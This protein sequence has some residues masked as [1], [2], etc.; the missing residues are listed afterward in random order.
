MPSPLTLKAASI[1]ELKKKATETYGPTAKVVRVE[2]VTQ[3]GIAGMFANEHFEGVIEIEPVSAPKAAAHGFADLTGVAALLAQ[4][5]AGENEMNAS[6]LPEVSTHGEDFTKLMESLNAE[7]VDTV[8]GPPTLSWAAGDL[9]L[10]AGTGVYALPVARAMAAEAG[11][12]LYTSGL[13]EADGVP[14]AEGPR[15]VMEARANGVL[16]GK[17]V[18]LAFGLGKPAWAASS[19]VTAGLLKADQVWLIVDA[20]HKPA[21]TESWG[22][23]AIK[24]LKPSALAVVGV[25]E[26]ASPSTVNTLGVPVGWVD[27]GPSATSALTDPDH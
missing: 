13:I 6:A 7:I 15:Q 22:G 21:D 14:A 18:V 3:G 5:D 10:V 20:R 19:A 16:T 4:A 1:E 24:L 11:G 2:K 9:V 26:T 17:P 23:T 12:V 8:P 25:T 27:D